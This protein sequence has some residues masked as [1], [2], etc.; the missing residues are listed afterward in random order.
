MP[1]SSS[2]SAPG[3]AGGRVGTAATGPLGRVA[4]TAGAV[5]DGRARLAALA[6]SGRGVAGARAGARTA[7]LAVPEVRAAC[8]AGRLWPVRRLE[9]GTL[10]G[11]VRCAAGL[12]A[13]ARTA[14]VLAA[15]RSLDAVFLL[16][17]SRSLRGGIR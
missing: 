17:I 14:G 5:F 16:A 7:G 3:R 2:R 10:R 8:V 12:R 11:S 9:A 13:P 1:S 4:V 6:V 15:F